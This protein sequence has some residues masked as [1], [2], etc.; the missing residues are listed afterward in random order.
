M[1]PFLVIQI[2]S[3]QELFSNIN[4]DLKVWNLKLLKDLILFF[5]FVR[6]PTNSLI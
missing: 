3:L 4:A 1:I 2:V 6:E 5:P